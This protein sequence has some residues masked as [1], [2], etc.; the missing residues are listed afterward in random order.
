MVGAF[1]KSS[2]SLEIY[3]TE[4]DEQISS[5]LNLDPLGLQVIWS[6]YGQNIFRNRLSSTS[7]DVRNYTLN[8]FNHA[9]VNSLIE[10]D[11]VQLGKRWLKDKAYA[12]RGKDAT[13]FRQACLIYLE[14]VFVYAMV[15]AQARPG[16][17]TTGV[18]GISKARGFWGSTTKGNPRLIFSHEPKAH[19]LTRQNSLGVSGRYKT[20]LVEMKFFNSSYDYALPEAQPQWEA[21]QRQLFS[22]TGPLGQ[23]KD[24]ACAHLS[25][26]LSDG[27]REAGHTL[28]DVPVELRKAFVDAFRS[29]ATVGA[30]ARDFWLGVTHLDQGAPGALY[31]VLEQEWKSRD[32]EGERPASEVFA[33]SLKQ[34]S[35]LKADREKLEHVRLLEPFLAELSLLFEAM[36]SD[37]S[38]LLDQARDKWTEL[39][40]DGNTLPDLAATISNDTVMHA[41]VSGTAAERLHELLELGRVTDVR[42][43]MVHLLKYHDKVMEARRQSS[44][45]RLIDGRQLKVDV[46]TRRLPARRERPV[47]AW[48]HHY[49]VP[50]FRH[51]LS[52]LRGLT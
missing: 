45:L 10:N 21:A 1:V 41:Q 50:Q 8:L 5:E 44:W 49:Y 29:P 40:R 25:E 23:L 15:E 33:M 20:P 12:G 32:Q 22:V 28:E 26:V 51:L 48:V 4:F 3:L 13:A 34:H 31:Q 47:G 24:L 35:L 37:K 11:R 7:N 14:N 30:Y 6:A 18:L 27:H 42:Q 46:R 2:G 9:V 17:E 19:V 39:G 43:Q 16:V 38:Q 36:L 52:G